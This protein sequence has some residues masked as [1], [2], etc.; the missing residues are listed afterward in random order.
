MSRLLPIL[1]G[2]VLVAGIAAM[3]FNSQQPT[4]GHS[5]NQPD[6]SGLEFG[7][8]IV[9]VTIPAS[10]SNEATIGQRGFE[11][12]CSV[13]HGEN[14]S[15]QNGVAP[16][17]VH[18]IYEPNHHGDGSIYN[19]AKNGVQ[20]HHWEFGDMPP[21]EGI[22]DADIKYIAAYIRSLQRENGIF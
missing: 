6:T 1:V 2:G 11:A 22:T 20:A 4:V 16:P 5:M 7:D 3:Y 21:V 18:I 12:K 17:L 14:G 9:A 10:F 15:G 19:A 13:C 8:P